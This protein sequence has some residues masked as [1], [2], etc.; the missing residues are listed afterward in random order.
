MPDVE[1]ASAGL[2]HVWHGLSITALTWLGT[3]G[4]LIGRTKAAGAEQCD[5]HLRHAA[6]CQQAVLAEQSKRPYGHWL[7]IFKCCTIC[8]GILLHAVAQLYW[9]SQADAAADRDAG[10]LKRL[11]L[12]E[13]SARGVMGRTVRSRSNYWQQAQVVLAGLQTAGA[14]VATMAA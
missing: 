5:L 2:V 12:L 14:A 13:R 11:L 1:M 8:D 9:Q 10:P 6:P 3:A 7:S 4:W